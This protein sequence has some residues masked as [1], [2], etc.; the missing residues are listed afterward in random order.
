MNLHSYNENVHSLSIVGD[1]CLAIN[2]LLS[3]ETNNKVSRIVNK[4]C[5]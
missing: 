5:N 4:T 1:N 2:I 3:V